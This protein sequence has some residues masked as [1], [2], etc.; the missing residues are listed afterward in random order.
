MERPDCRGAKGPARRIR[1]PLLQGS[2]AGSSGRHPESQRTSAHYD[3]D[4]RQEAQPLASSDRRTLD[5]AIQPLCQRPALGP[6]LCS[7]LPVSSVLGA[8]VPQST[9]L[10]GKPHARRRHRFP[11]MLQRFSQ[12][13]EARTSPR[14]RRH[15]DCRGS[16]ELRPEMAD[17]LHSVLYGNRAA[18]KQAAGTG[19]SSPRSNSATI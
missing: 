12:M 15:F 4:R 2:K 3:R 14:T 18:H 16:L 11:A 7:H 13:R 8:G 5:R 1:R 10:A 6:D 17:P 19:C 9:S